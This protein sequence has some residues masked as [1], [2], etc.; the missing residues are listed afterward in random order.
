MVKYASQSFKGPQLR[1]PTIEKKAT[2]IDFAL[3]KWRLFLIGGRFRLETDHRPLKWLRSMKDTNEKLGRMATRIAQFEPL[4]VV[5]I[6]G[7]KNVE[8]DY[9]SRLFSAISL[10]YS[11]H[12]DVFFRQQKKA[13]DFT[14]NGKGR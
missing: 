6:L 7:K 12:D 3:K 14:T 4:D 9:L 13:N 2:T 5:H 1:Y 10:D 8:A 11:D